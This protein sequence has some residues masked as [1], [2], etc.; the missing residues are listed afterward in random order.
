MYYRQLTLGDNFEFDCDH[1]I[2]NCTIQQTKCFICYKDLEPG[3][4][5]TCRENCRPLAMLYGTC[6]RCGLPSTFAGLTTPI[7]PRTRDNELNLGQ[8]C[9]SKGGDFLLPLSNALFYL[10]EYKRQLILQSNSV[11]EYVKGWFRIDD[12]QLW[13]TTIRQNHTSGLLP[14]IICIFYWLEIV[15]PTSPTTQ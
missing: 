11:P 15:K 14:A 3:D 1:G 7:H 12:F 4:T 2:L 6:Y 10:D 8:Y 13:F 9:Q 5:R